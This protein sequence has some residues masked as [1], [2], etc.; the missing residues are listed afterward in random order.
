MQKYYFLWS[1]FYLGLTSVVTQYFIG[2]FGILLCRCK[3]F[4]I[5]EK[6]VEWRQAFTGFLL[7]VALASFALN[8]IKVL[9]ETDETFI[10]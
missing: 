9:I 7:V 5:H 10:H 4:S 1:D 2:L 6:N 3:R 8:A